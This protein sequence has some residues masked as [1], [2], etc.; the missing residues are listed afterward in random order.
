MRNLQLQRLSFHGR[1]A[2][3]AL[4]LTGA[5]VAGD[6]GAASAEPISRRSR[7]DMGATAEGSVTGRPIPRRQV[8]PRISRSVNRSRPRMSVA[9]APSPVDVLADVWAKLRHCESGGRYNVNSGNGFF[10]AYQFTAATWRGLG[11]PGLPHQA[12]P[13]VQDEAAR[14]LQARSG[15]GQWP[16][17]SR[18]LG[19]R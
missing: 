4:L 9:A 13:E 7:P 5:L 18:R 16:A 14:R 12:A 8:R 11:F 2:V 15:W 1:P 10:G 19:V 17:C 6:A 3:A